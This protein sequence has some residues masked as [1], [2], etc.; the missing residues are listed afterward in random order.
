MTAEYAG[1]VDQL[2]QPPPADLQ[3]LFRAPYLTK[4]RNSNLAPGSLTSDFV[5][6]QAPTDEAYRMTETRT[7]YVEAPRARISTGTVLG[8]ACAFAAGMVALGVAFGLRRRIDRVAGPP[9]DEDD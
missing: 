3:P 6:R 1:P 5:A 9:P 4:L 2:A 7:V 8:L